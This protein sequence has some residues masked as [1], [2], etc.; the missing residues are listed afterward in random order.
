M[1]ASYGQSCT[2]HCPWSWS[3]G[4]WKE[5]RLEG[6]SSAMS[7]EPFNKFKWRDITDTFFANVGPNEVV[8]QMLMQQ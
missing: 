5:H 7:Y 2:K 4:V 8:A 3:G 6:E 1:L